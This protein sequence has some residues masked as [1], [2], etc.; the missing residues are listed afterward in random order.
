MF[1]RIQPTS[2]PLISERHWQYQEPRSRFEQQGEHRRRAPRRWWDSAS[3]AP[4]ISEKHF[5]RR[6]VHMGRPKGATKLL[7]EDFLALSVRDLARAGVFTRS[8]GTPCTCTWNDA[9]VELHKINCYLG[10]SFGSGLFLRIAGSQV[11]QGAHVSQT[12]QLET[13]QRSYGGNKFLFLCPGKHGQVSC[14]RQVRKLYFVEG[15]WLCRHCGNLTYLARRQHDSRKDRLLRDPHLLLTALQSDDP[16]QRLLGIAA[17]AQALT[18][19]QR[20]RRQPSEIEVQNLDSGR[21]WAC[22]RTWISVLPVLAN[23][24]F[25]FV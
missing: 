18:R 8:I 9:G 11:G 10:G 14:G 7:V 17:W 25:N 20:Y 19:L 15:K 6:H 22:T 23:H 16:R 12:I 2:A 13:P 3:H 1:A 5:A 4:L 21:G 24:F